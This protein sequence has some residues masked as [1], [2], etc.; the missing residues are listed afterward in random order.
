VGNLRAPEVIV[1]VE[2]PDVVVT[3]TISKFVP[4]FVS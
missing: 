4:R 1:T 2:E 3:S